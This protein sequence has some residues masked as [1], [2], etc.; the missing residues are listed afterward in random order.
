MTEQVYKK[1]G[2]RY[3]P[4]G[5]S[6]GWK[7][8][9]SEGVWIV[10]NKHGGKSSECIMKMGELEQMRPAADLILEYKDEILDYMRTHTREGVS[11]NDYVNDM[12]KEITKNNKI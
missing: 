1:R 10:K 11:L 4:V 6:D 9:P 2:R 7:G 12:L 3:V 5:Y 8:F